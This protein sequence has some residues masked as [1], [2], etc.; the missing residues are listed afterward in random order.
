MSLYSQ[1]TLAF[2]PSGYKE[3]TLFSVAPSNGTGDIAFSRT[4]DASR[5]NGS[6]ILQ[7]TPWNLIGNS[8]AFNNWTQNSCTIGADVIAAPDGTMTADSFSETAT[9]AQHL[10]RQDP[11]Y[12]AGYNYT[13]S[14]YAKAGTQSTL[15]IAMSFTAFGANWRTAYFNLSNGTVISNNNNSGIAPTITNVG[16]GWYRCTFTNT[17]TTT[18]A[19]ALSFGQD[20]FS[21]LGN[22]LISL[23]L[24]GAQLEISSSATTYITTTNRQN[25]PQLD[26]EGSTCPYL[27]MDNTSTN[28][29]T[30]SEDLANAAWTR[31]NTTVGSN[32]ILAPNGMT[33]GDKL[34]ADTVNTQHGIS[35]SI[36]SVTV[37]Q[38]ITRSVYVKKAEYANVVLTVGSFAAYNDWK[39]VAFNLNTNTFTGASGATTYGYTSVGNGWVRIW[40]TVTVTT[41]STDTFTIKISNDPANAGQGPT[42]AGDGVSGLY[43]W[44][45]Q[46]E[47][48]S[49]PSSYI[50]TYGV[51]STRNIQSMSVNNL[52]TNNILS[53]DFT[54]YSDFTD[55]KWSNNSG[56]HIFGVGNATST[57]WLAIYRNFS[58]LLKISKKENN[59]V[60]NTNN[61]NVQVAEG[62]PIKVAIK[63]SAGA[64]K[65]Y[66]NGQLAYTTTFANPSLMTNSRFFQLDSGNGNM[67]RVRAILLY[68]T[69]L[70]DAECI[71]LT[72]P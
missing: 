67:A 25:V 71:K 64:V 50:P 13:A 14:V 60:T 36:G 7:K 70:T 6:G 12:I 69:A 56:I 42:F 41:A 52:Q 15:C 62:T 55:Y 34:I 49:Y 26:W 32:V 9:T 1:A 20:F 3:G 53:S 54:L 68:N 35:A 46:S 57:D 47:N 17:C 45:M 10:V 28:I 38:V 40:F 72:T 8:Q 37:G 27:N 29:I 44:G 21:H 65:I 2:I 18:V 5:L 11:Q 4:T 66:I 61:L 31:S 30:Y 23:Y 43:V 33:N 59:V 58:S 19:D 24:W 16:N 63:C 22:G 51:T 39:Y 48:R